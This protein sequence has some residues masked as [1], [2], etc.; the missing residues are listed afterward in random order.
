[1]F[2]FA[3]NVLLSAIFLSLATYQSIYPLTLCAPALLYL[4]QVCFIIFSLP[5]FE[6]LNLISWI[7][8]FVWCQSMF[9]FLLSQRQY[10]PVNFRRVSFWWF[11]TQYLFMYLGSLFV[12]IC[13]SFFLLGSWDYLP[14]VYGF[15]WVR[16]QKLEQSFLCFLCGRISCLREFGKCNIT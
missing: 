14:S 1:M 16:K 11:I 15:M 9:L 8:A 12:M 10:I 7:S 13:L 6:Y 4:M 3:G 5:F 2:V